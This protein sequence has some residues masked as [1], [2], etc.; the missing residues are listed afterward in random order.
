MPE[1]SLAK[2]AIRDVS[3]HDGF[4]YLAGYNGA[5]NNPVLFAFAQ[6]GTAL[7]GLCVAGKGA[8]DTFAAA[9]FDRAVRSYRRLLLNSGYRLK[10]RRRGTVVTKPKATLLINDTHGIGE[11]PVGKAFIYLAGHTSDRNNPAVYAFA[12]E[13]ED[14]L[15][16]VGPSFY[17]S[18][19]IGAFEDAMKLYRSL[20]VTPPKQAVSEPLRGS[21]C[22][23]TFALVLALLALAPTWY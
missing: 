16:I 9:H 18:V 14:R 21:G 3:P 10:T 17:E 19:S 15:A 1:E 22:L 12:S 13:G 23:P 11:I 5:G 20:L 6:D 4:P 7:A 8:L 2:K